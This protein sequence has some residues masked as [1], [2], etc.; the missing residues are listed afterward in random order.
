MTPKGADSA[1]T[2]TSRDLS[3]TVDPS[4]G[5]V[6]S[7]RHKN[8]RE[9]AD[10]TSRS[11]D[12]IYRNLW[13]NLW[14]KVHK[15][16]DFSSFQWLGEPWTTG[17]Q[18]VDDGNKLVTS[19]M[20]KFCV[21]TIRREA[22]DD[23]IE[24]EYSLLAREPFV[25]EAFGVNLRPRGNEFVYHWFHGDDLGYFIVSPCRADCPKLA[26]V[27]ADGKLQ[28]MTLDGS[29][30]GHP[31]YP[32]LWYV[33]SVHHG[34]LDE[35]PNVPIA[36]DTGR[37]IRMVFRYFAF[38]SWDEFEEKLLVIGRQ[39][40]FRYDRAVEVGDTFTM[41][42]V[43]PEGASL[44]G[45]DL[46]G[47]PVRAV[48][49]CAP[50]APLGRFEACRVQTTVARSGLLKAN[51]HYVANGADRHSFVL[52]EGMH[53]LHDLLQK[54]VDY[55][56]AHQQ[57]T[58]PSSKL[59]G[60]IFMND[61]LTREIYTNDTRG[62]CQTGGVGEITM[63]AVAVVMKNRL[64]GN[65]RQG[66]IERIELHANEW[67]RGI[68]QPPGQW[69]VLLNPLWSDTKFRM[70]GINA[71]FTALEYLELSRVPA[72]CLKRQTR[73][74]YLI[75]AYNTLRHALLTYAGT[76]VFG[77]SAAF[78]VPE[79][80]RELSVRGYRDEAASLD[81]AWDGFVGFVRRGVRSFAAATTE[82]GSIF[83]DAGISSALAVLVLHDRSVDPESPYL[84]VLQNFLGYS[85][86]MRLQSA[87]RS[88]DS[89]AGDCYYK[90]NA[91]TMPQLWTQEEAFTL[92]QVYEVTGDERH[93]RQAYE[94]MMNFYEYYNFDYE[95][96]EWGKMSLGQAHASFF[97]AFELM[98]L[99]L[100]NPPRHT[101][102]RTCSDQDH[103]LV[104]YLA[105]LGQTCYVTR[106]GHC[107]NCKREGDKLVSKAPFSRR[108]Y[109]SDLR[110]GKEYDIRDVFAGRLLDTERADDLGRLVFEHRE[111]VRAIALA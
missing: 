109:I 58:D 13:G 107:Y 47:V 108:F 28:G 68:A 92:L 80:V 76:N 38:E 74:T 11:N 43:L 104:L 57:V 39:P 54:R 40:V 45:V 8:G 20:D 101:Q 95:W 17:I 78:V 83:D 18:T 87:H 56:L 14:W 62:T 3:M 42:V 60:G 32:S 10:C 110:A 88:W 66:E 2:L 49:S 41:T 64:E 91:L 12:G 98:D 72:Q 93:L 52:F 89:N 96:N 99:Y 31:Q 37:L 4:Y 16:A 30:H 23:C 7:L 19:S 103:A 90:V 55:I 84:K 1:V 77:L 27:L 71:P 59:F 44:C 5:C 85:Y 29:R 86:D 33:D 25:L 9:V 35:Y 34:K 48:S 50:P 79:L 81:A 82:M 15:W 51:V 61:L 24:E 65:Y 100:A 67:I 105:S 22:S 6:T 73:D 21:A 46:D 106:E 102:E 97:P 75:W 111:T 63:S 70:A 36:M 94:S 69:D 53:D 26:M